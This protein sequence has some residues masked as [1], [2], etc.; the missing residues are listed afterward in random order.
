MEEATLRREVRYN[1][2]KLAAQTT[3]NTQIHIFSSAAHLTA[4]KLAFLM[5]LH[6]CGEFEVDFTW[7]TLLNHEPVCKS[8]V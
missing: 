6:M 7:I 2:D 3:I 4:S 8:N 5:N 1:L